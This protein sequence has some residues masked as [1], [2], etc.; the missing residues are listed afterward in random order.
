MASAN[1]T[2]QPS[3]PSAPFDVLHIGFGP[4]SLA[5]AIS[6][7]ESN[8]GLTKPSPPTYSS[9]GG[10]QQALG[11]EPSKDEGNFPSST[12]LSRPVKACYLEKH[13]RFRWHP[14]MMIEGSTMQISFVSLSSSLPFFSSLFFLSVLLRS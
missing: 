5:L 11:F 10:L 2:T 7:V 4:A 12:P 1:S 8:S 14:G 6:T 3:S 9:L 13:E